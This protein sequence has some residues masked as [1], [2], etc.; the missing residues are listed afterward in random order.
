MLL[1]LPG[2][3]MRLTTRGAPEMSTATSSR[4]RWLVTSATFDGVIATPNGVSPPATPFCAGLTMPGRRSSSVTALPWSRRI[5]EIESL[6]MLAATTRVPSGETAR[7]ETT[8]FCARP[9][10]TPLWPSATEAASAYVGAGPAATALYWY[11]TSST[12]P[13]TKNEPPSGA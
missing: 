3:G 6:K 10:P 5:T 9:T 11:T 12:P 2:S 1:G 4:S 7:P 13:E 8:G